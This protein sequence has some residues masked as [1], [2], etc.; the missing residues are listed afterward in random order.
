MKSEGLKVGKDF[1]KGVVE[2]NRGRVF[3]LGGITFVLLV[4]LMIM[5]GQM[6][7]RQ[8]IGPRPTLPLPVLLAILPLIALAAIDRRGVGQGRPGGRQTNWPLTT[9]YVLPLLFI[10]LAV[11]PGL[12]TQFLIAAWPGLLLLYPLTTV[13]YVAHL[14]LCLPTS[15]S[16]FFAKYSLKGRGYTEVI[17]RK[18][19]LRLKGLPLHN[20]LLA[21]GMGALPL[22][23]VA[24]L[25]L[26][27]ASAANLEQMQALLLLSTSL[28]VSYFN[29]GA[30]L[31]SGKRVL[32]QGLRLAD[33]RRLL[34]DGKTVRGSAAGLTMAA[35]VASATFLNLEVGLFIG[36]CT[37]TGDL[38]ASFIK[39]RLGLARG[40]PV[41]F[42]DQL[43][44]VALLIATEIGW[45]IIGL[46]GFALLALV[47]ITLLVQ[48][49]GNV[50]L[51]A[52]GK[53]NVPW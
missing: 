3:L 8:L 4:T 5:T 44:S 33:G 29:L 36:A 50:L 11:D 41:I 10:T 15:F 51:F 45:G 46:E 21:L 35:A 40:H 30:T 39:R 49:Y 31:F 7:G 22:L 9:L 16:T 43:D 42:L 52:V 12:F 47:V 48:L 24:P 19:H 20:P 34:G 32:D 14:L 25:N 18:R 2:R 38:L 23:L 27:V 26:L 1:I 37:M 13:A 17:W 53:K 6:A 28:A